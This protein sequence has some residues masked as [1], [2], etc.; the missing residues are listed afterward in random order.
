MIDRGA[1]SAKLHSLAWKV[2]LLGGNSGA[3]KTTLARQ[4]GIHFSVQWSQVDDFRLVLQRLTTPE[5][6]Q[7]LHFFVNQDGLKDGIWEQ[8]VENL[9]Q[10]LTGVGQTVS[11]ALDVVAAH[12]IAAAT[13][14]ILEG[15]GIVPAFAARKTYAGHQSGLGDVRGGAGDVRAVFVI[16]ENEEALLGT[17]QGRGAGYGDKP[18][19]E[20]RIHA[21]MNWLYG[22]WLAQ[23]ARH[24][25]LPIVAPRPWATLFQRTLEEIA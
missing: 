21:R 14:L 2:L 10:G 19:E 11:D 5:Q 9:V 20:Q 6:Q 13:P 4:L 15:D 25:R 8:P 16:E 23:E 7:D 1:S 3:G 12:H 24:Y 18:S 22:Q 17:L